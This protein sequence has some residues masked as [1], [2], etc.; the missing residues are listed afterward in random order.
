MK[1]YLD[2]ERDIGNTLSMYLCM[3][4]YDLNY[5]QESYEMNAYVR[6]FIGR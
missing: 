1:V 4:R 3:L 2:K 5:G 6:S